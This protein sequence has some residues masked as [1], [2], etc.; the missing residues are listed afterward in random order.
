MHKVVPVILLAAL[1]TT[2]AFADIHTPPGNKY[3]ATRKLS[4]ALANIF[5]GPLEISSSFERSLNEGDAR[6]AFSHGIVNGI[7]RAGIRMGYGFYELV[8]FRTPNYK[9][10]Y[11]PPYASDKYDSVHGYTEFPAAAG[12]TA[13]DYVRRQS[14]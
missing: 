2:A 10:S 6:E 7:D 8:H 14:Y 13:S 4:R 5:Y 11:R 3:T 9:E 1:A 12:F